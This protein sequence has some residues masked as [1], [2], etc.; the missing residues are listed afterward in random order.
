[1]KKTLNITKI[2]KIEKVIYLLLIIGI[3]ILGITD[4]VKISVTKNKI[5]NSIDIIENSIDNARK[6]QEILETS[7]IVLGI[8]ANEITEPTVH[9][10]KNSNIFIT[11]ELKELYKSSFSDFYLY[12]KD[13]NGKVYKVKDVFEETK[14]YIDAFMN[15][16]QQMTSNQV[17]IMIISLS[18]TNIICISIIVGL[19]KEESIL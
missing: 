17:I 19:K 10:T 6:K 2:E 18:V 9:S 12:L 4:L 5:E 7:K 16:Y 15:N 3:I 8:S 11:N 13:F 1:M 14:G